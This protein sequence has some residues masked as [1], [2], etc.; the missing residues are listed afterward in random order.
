[1]AAES[2]SSAAKNWVYSSGLISTNSSLKSFLAISSSSFCAPASGVESTVFVV[3]SDFCSSPFLSSF[4]VGVFGS[5]LAA[6][7]SAVELSVLVVS[8]SCSGSSSLLTGPEDGLFPTLSNLSVP[9]SVSEESLFSRD[10][11]RGTKRSVSKRRA[12][13]KECSAL[14]KLRFEIVC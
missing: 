6:S 10:M 1:M 3:V 8:D 11:K 4:L 9:W 14:S 13:K 12:K 7:G 2:L 5:S